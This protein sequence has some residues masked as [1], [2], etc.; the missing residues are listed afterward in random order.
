[1]TNARTSI[2]VAFLINCHD[3]TI[4]LRARLVSV[5]VVVITYDL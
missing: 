3:F 5:D 2:Y 4:F 1:M